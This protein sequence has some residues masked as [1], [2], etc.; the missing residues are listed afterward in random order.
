MTLRPRPA[1]HAQPGTR[2][3]TLREVT[4]ET[5]RA[6]CALDVKE[7]QRRFVAPNAVSIAQA[8]FEPSAFFR[9]VY[10]GEVAVGFIMYRSADEDGVCFLWRFMIDRN[11]QGRGYGTEALAL[12]LLH[13]RAQ[14]FTRLRTSYVV[15]EAGPRAFYETIG[16]KET[17]RSL[18]NGERLIEMDL[19]A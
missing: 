16:F 11:H 18:A 1:S 13:I 10:A 12:L 4:A 2:A 9:A 7:E 19:P 8:Y 17:G 6:V 5:V 3:V 15:G 14:G